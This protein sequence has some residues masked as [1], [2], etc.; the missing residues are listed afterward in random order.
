[1]KKIIFDSGL[2]V[3]GTNGKDEAYWISLNDLFCQFSSANDILMTVPHYHRSL[4]LSKILMKLKQ[5]LKI[6]TA[7]WRR[8]I[9]SVLNRLQP[10]SHVLWHVL[11]TEWYVC[12]YIKLRTLNCSLFTKE[13]YENIFHVGLLFLV[14]LI[15]LN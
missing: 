12:E 6:M 15:D 13:F 11:H 5:L 7:Q 9:V 4:S 8:T 10:I 2:M 1:M 3:N 14:Y